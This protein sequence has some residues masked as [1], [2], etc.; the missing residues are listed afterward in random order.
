[1][2]ALSITFGVFALILVL[3][4]LRVPL[5]AAIAVSCL[6]L[7]LA[8]GLGAGSTAGAFL[9]GALRP[10]TI[11]LGVVTT[12]LLGLSGLLQSA[13]QFDRLV[14]LARALFRRPAV[15]MAAL[16][17]FVGLL[18]MPG[19][20]LFSAPMVRS[21]SGGSPVR[22]GQLSA[23]N[24]WFRHIWE[25]WWPLYPGVLTAVSVTDISMGRFVAQQWPLGVLMAA[26]GLLILGR[27]QPEL[28][29]KA[30]PAP[31]GTLWRLLTA[32]LP[33]WLILLVFAAG[34][35]VLAAVGTGGMSPP[36]AGAVGKFLPIT[37]GL[38]VSLA[39][40]IRL[41]GVSRRQVWLVFTARR[42]YAV[43]SVACAVMIFQHMIER[44]GAAGRI[45]EEFTA[46]RVPVV[47]I[48]AAL[49]LVAGMVTG[50][51]IG[52]VGTSFPIVLALV[53][54]IP[55]AG[56]IGPYVA[57]AYAFGHLGQMLSPIHLCQVVSNRFFET[58]YL[59][60]YRE[61]IPSAI[62][63]AVGSVGYFL[64]LRWLMAG[65]A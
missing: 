4:R 44:V 32:G 62:L 63:T 48:V 38:L 43:V 9:A 28:H 50:L 39:V 19:G 57:L 42:L 27:M 58:T 12:L 65:G 47:L 13:G 55:D 49:P 8:F 64:L 34:S 26:T 14:N 30:P 21:A 36:L 25:H 45:A 15:S 6:A 54:A 40:T 29:A 3:A 33:I 5:S 23:I 18:P 2:P 46:I 60:T 51:A 24:Y 35:A 16:P 53:R 52:F 11:A 41:H 1:M 20:A 31:R 61:M 22:A 37:L 56:P 7:G 10:N 17:A 59:S